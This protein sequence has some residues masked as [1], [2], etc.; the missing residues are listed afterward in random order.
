MI[1]KRIRGAAAIIAA[2]MLWS[3]HAAQAGPF[4]SIDSA[5]DE[6]VRFDSTT[7]AVTVVGALGTDVGDVDLTRTADGRLWGINSIFG[8][9]VDLHEI[10]TTTGAVLSTTQVNLSGIQNAEGL[11]HSGN[12]LVIGHSASSSASNIF[13]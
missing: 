5:T 8:D 9:R 10:N 4:F 3:G 12:Q 1:S 6:L 13:S 11:G 7:G 2:A